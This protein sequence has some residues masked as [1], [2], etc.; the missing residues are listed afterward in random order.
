MWDRMPGAVLTAPWTDSHHSITVTPASPPP[1]PISDPTRPAP[2][3][4]CHGLSHVHSCVGKKN[5]NKKQRKKK[6]NNNKSLL[7]VPRIRNRGCL[8]D[9]VA[10]RWAWRHL[11]AVTNSARG[12]EVIPVVRFN[13]ISP[14]NHLILAARAFRGPSFSEVTERGNPQNRVI[15]FK[16]STPVTR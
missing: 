7:L 5:P 10:R 3:H 12:V 2:L 1:L 16:H 9:C 14:D 11:I 6:A 4:I 15:L 8:K 13:Q